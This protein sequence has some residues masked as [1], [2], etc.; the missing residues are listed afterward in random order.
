AEVVGGLRRALAERDARGLDEMG[1]RRAA[2]PDPGLRR[3]VPGLFR[4]PLSPDVRRALR[5]L[6]RDGD[7][8]VRA[9][10][11]EVLAGEEP[12]QEHR[13]LLSDLLRDPD[14][15]VVRRTVRAL[16]RA[17]DGPPE[18]AELLVRCLDSEDQDIRLSAAYGLAV[19]DDP[20][21]PGAYARIGPLRP[22]YEHDPRMDG[23]WR[24]RHR[25]ET[26]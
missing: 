3:R 22:G 23:L 1:L 15:E 4:P 19:R 24:W 6:C 25:N 21:T 11:A 2:N 5:D 8:A 16:G 7:G 26:D 18:T 17:A 13:E 12:G 10:A 9:S 20:R 14:P